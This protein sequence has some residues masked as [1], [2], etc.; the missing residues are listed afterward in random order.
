MPSLFGNDKQRAM[1]T[2]F[3]AIQQKWTGPEGLPSGKKDRE[4]VFGLVKADAKDVMDVLKARYPVG[5]P[6]HAIRKVAAEIVCKAKKE[7]D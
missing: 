7:M 1:A 3:G 2:L 4:F 5:V 6:A